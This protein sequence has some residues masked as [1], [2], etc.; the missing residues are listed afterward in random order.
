V[1]AFYAK[2]LTICNTVSQAFDYLQDPECPADTCR[3]LLKTFCSHSTSVSSALDVFYENVLQKF[4]FW[5]G[6]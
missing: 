4:I 5:Q 6:T 2:A 3:Q 1:T